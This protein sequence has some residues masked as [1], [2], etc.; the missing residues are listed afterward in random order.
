MNTEQEQTLTQGY[1][2]RAAANLQRQAAPHYKDEDWKYTHFP[3]FGRYHRLTDTQHSH[4]ENPFPPGAP[5]TDLE[6]A[7]TAVVVNGRLQPRLSRL[8]HPASGIRL[9]TL[10]DAKAEGA[11]P[12]QVS[13]GE[14]ALSQGNYYSQ[15]AMAQEA[16]GLY[17]S[18]EE[19]KNA[20]KPLFIRSITDLSRREQVLPLHNVIVVAKNAR[21]TLSEIQEGSGPGLALSLQ[22]VHLGEQSQLWHNQIQLW[23]KERESIQQVLVAQAGGSQYAHFAYCGGGGKTR[24]QLRITLLGPQAHSELTGLVLPG[25]GEQIDNQTLVHHR[26]P[27]TGSRQRYRSVVGK[28]GTSVFNGKVFVEPEAQKTDAYQHH[29]SLLL[30][31]TSVS[32]AKPELEIYADDVKCSHGAT[33]GMLD[34][35]EIHYMRTRGLSEQQ[36][37]LMLL[38]AFVRDLLESL[39]SGPLRH[40]CLEHCGRRLGLLGE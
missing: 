27:N 33:T 14:L 20:D 9:C 37:R 36:A 39:K 3:D 31:E 40:W 21:L 6:D 16:D 10:R 1:T 26:S 18:I 32:N 17:I 35:G 19:G 15:W 23:G 8:P 22:E 29:A 25:S 4:R 5:P 2:A 34:A 12:G 7:W 28:E 11:W 24:N 38:E 30:H 13:P